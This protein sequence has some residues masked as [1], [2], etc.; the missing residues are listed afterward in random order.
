MNL[1]T[2]KVGD[3]VDRYLGCDFRMKPM[4]LIVSEVNEKEIVCGDWKFSKITG[5]EIDEYLGW[6]GYSTGSVIRVENVN[7]D[8]QSN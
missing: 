5:G 4:K 7:F 3:T 8:C 2:V 6:D 1:S